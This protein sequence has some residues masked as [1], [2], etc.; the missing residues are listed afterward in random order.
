MTTTPDPDVLI[1]A[2]LD[3]GRDEL[4]DRAFDAVRRDIHQTR[5]RVVIGPWREPRM[6]LPARLAA[7]VAALLVVALG[8]AVVPGL[9]GGSPAPGATASPTA[10][11]VDA[12]PRTYAWPAALEAGTYETSLI[13]S[14]ELRFRFT[15][16]DGWSSRDIGVVKDGTAAFLIY[17]AGNVYDDLCTEGAA[18]PPIAPDPDGIAGALADLV[19]VTSGPTATT[20]AGRAGVR[21]EYDLAPPDGCEAGEAHVIELAAPGCQPGCGPLGPSYT[22]LEFRDGPEHHRMWILELGRSNLIV[23]AISTDETSPADLAELDAIVDSFS[24]AVPGASPP[25]QP[26]GSQP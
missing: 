1:Q 18:D 16:P 8:I 7:P 10:S 15:V 17:I 5:Q 3:E 25:P 11:A 21:L 26:A 24:F 19:T 6:T 13:W 20:L 14:P 9:I 12:S 4:P 2:F 22:G 23:E